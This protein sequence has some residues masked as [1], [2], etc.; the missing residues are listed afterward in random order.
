MGEQRKRKETGEGAP[1][2]IIIINCYL[3]NTSSRCGPAGADRKACSVLAGKG[4][5]GGCRQ[6]AQLGLKDK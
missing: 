5:G 1:Q 6:E 4:P 3:P 2:A